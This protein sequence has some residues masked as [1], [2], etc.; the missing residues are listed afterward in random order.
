[1]RFE[2]GGYLTGSDIE[3]SISSGSTG[4]PGGGKRRA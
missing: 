1:M 2:H 3:R 4:A